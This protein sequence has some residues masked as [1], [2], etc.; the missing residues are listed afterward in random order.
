MKWGEH[1]HD[2]FD[3]TERFFRASYLGNCLETWLPAV[4]DIVQRLKDGISVADL[5]CG[6][7]ASTIIMAERFPKS[8]FIGFDDHAPSIEAAQHIASSKKHDNLTFSVSGAQNFVGN[9][10][11]LHFSI[12]FMTWVIR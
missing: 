8:R 12:V 6:H 9:T 3:G 4:S 5:G 7:G 10:I 1:H 11:L 2:L